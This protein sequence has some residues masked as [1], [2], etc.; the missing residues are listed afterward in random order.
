MPINAPSQPEIAR[1]GLSANWL[2]A[3]MPRLEWVGL[4]NKAPIATI[5]AIAAAKRNTAFHGSASRIQPLMNGPIA[6]PVLTA[7]KYI[8]EE[9]VRDFASPLS[10]SFIKAWKELKKSDIPKGMMLK[11]SSEILIFSKKAKMRQS[12]EMSNAAAT[13][14]FF[15]R[16]TFTILLIE[17]EKMT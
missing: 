7:K 3:P 1:S 16:A 17:R 15:A 12:A 5:I 9:Y 10:T 8:L 13:I 11:T 14:C 2:L 4:N 6:N